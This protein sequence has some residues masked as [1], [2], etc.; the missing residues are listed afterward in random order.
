MEAG[1][2][3][4]YSETGAGALACH[5]RLPTPSALPHSPINQGGPICPSGRHSCSQVLG[6][7]GTGRMLVFLA[8]ALLPRP[9]PHLSAPASHSGASARLEA[10]R[11][12]VLPLSPVPG[13]H[14]HLITDEGLCPLLHLRGSCVPLSI[15]GQAVRPLLEALCHH[16]SPPTSSLDVLS[17]GINM[18]SRLFA[19]KAR[20]CLPSQIYLLSLVNSLPLHPIPPP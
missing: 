16:P 2:C 1:P 9:D 15:P 10:S 5:S 17:P 18:L 14:W 7:P 8:P 6:T 11:G 12:Q 19:L 20:S 4:P 3:L 13:F